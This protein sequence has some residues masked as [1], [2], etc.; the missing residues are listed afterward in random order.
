V[1]AAAVRGAAARV[2]TCACMRS[3]GA[4]AAA[5]A[6][7]AARPPVAASVRRKMA[8]KGTTA[9]VHHSRMLTGMDS[10]VAS[11]CGR[12]VACGC[13]EMRWPF[14]AGA[15]RVSRRVGVDVARTAAGTAP[16]ARRGAVAAAGTGRVK[17]TGP[18]PGSQN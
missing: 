7:S 1:S 6:A 3:G 11:G 16:P 17:R 5:S 14:G 8:G 15:R 10:V 9:F 12:V 18:E 2:R 13:D 4:A